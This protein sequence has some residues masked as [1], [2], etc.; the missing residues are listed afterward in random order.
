MKVKTPLCDFCLR[1]GILCVRCQEKLRSGEISERDV[2]IA[3]ELLRLSER[4]PSIQKVSFHKSYEVDDVIAILVD[5]GDLPHLLGYDGKVLKALSKV[6]GKKIRVLEKGAS[7]RKFLEDLLTPLN[8]ASLNKVWLPDG[9]TET[10]VILS[11]RPRRLPISIETL[12]ALAEK[13]RGMAV[14]VEFEAP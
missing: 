12:R 6:T 11:G 13:M 7:A 14:R 4:Y 8:I 9:T 2:Q 3:R 1:S 5:P 10:K